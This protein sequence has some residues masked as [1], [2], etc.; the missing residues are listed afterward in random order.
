MS[1]RVSELMGREGGGLPVS[2]MLFEGG[3]CVGEYM[4]RE[5]GVE[6]QRVT[7]GP[8]F[9]LDWRH[10]RVAWYEASTGRLDRYDTVLL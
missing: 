3:E 6:V 9:G 8:A 4:A 1:L 5:V 2:L 7:R 10:V